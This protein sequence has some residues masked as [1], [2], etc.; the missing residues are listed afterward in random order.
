[1]QCLAQNTELEDVIFEEEQDQ[2]CP[3][4]PQLPFSNGEAEA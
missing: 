1:M 2:I 3:S 4:P